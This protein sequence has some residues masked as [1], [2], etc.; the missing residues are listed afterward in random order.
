MTTCGI[1]L[2]DRE[3]HPVDRRGRGDDAV[4]IL[5]VHLRLLH[6]LPTAGRTTVPIGVL[7]RLAVVRRGRALVFV[8]IS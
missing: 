7:G 1:D 6:A 3:S 8:V 4:E 2:A 5:W